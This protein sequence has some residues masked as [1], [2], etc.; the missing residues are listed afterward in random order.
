M[1]QNNNT[2]DAEFI[3]EDGKSNQPNINR[4]EPRDNLKDPF[5]N[6]NSNQEKPTDDIFNQRLTS[7]R[8]PDHE[9]KD[10]PFGF[11]SGLDGLNEA[12]KAEDPFGF[13]AHD[14]KDDDPFGGGPGGKE[15]GGELNLD[16]IGGNDD[17]DF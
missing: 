13:D 16:F 4:N 8:K 5:S 17:E 1:E 14:D 12:K 6:S 7:N 9:I 3:L 2:N 10:D 11:D 15:T